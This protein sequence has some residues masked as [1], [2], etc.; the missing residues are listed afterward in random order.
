MT[1][2]DK[3]TSGRAGALVLAAALLPMFTHPAQADTTSQTPSTPTP[4]ETQIPDEWPDEPEGF[5]SVEAQDQDGTTGGHGG[6]TVTATTFEELREY[7]AVE[8]PLTI[9]IEGK[10]ESDDLGDM[11][12]VSSDTT[13]IGTG[14]DA[15]LVGGGF[16]LDEVHNVIIRNMTI[17]D[18]YVPGDWDGKDEDNDNDGIRMD[19]AHHVWVDHVAF[20]R[21]GDGMVDV[22]HGSTYVTLSWNVFA[23]HNKTL[24]IG[25]TDDV[26]THITMHHNW[27]RNTYQRNASTDNAAA[28]H[29]YNNRFERIG[30]YGMW[31]RGQTSMLLENNHFLH[32]RDPYFADEEA[33]LV[34]RG[35][36]LEDSPGLKVERGQAFDPEEHYNYRAAPADDVPDLVGDGAGPTTAIG[37]GEPSEPTEPGTTITVAL[38]GSA[39]FTSL[40]AA[41]GAIPPERQERT[42][43]TLAPGT[44]HERVNI[45]PDLPPITLQ[46][47]SEDPEDTVVSYEDSAGTTKYYLDQTHGTSGSASV[48]VLG[49][50]FR[51]E[52]ITFA[53]TFDEEEHADQEGHQA[54]A[55]RSVGDRAVLD[56]VRVLGN[57]DTLLLDTPGTDQVRRTHLT[58]CYVEGDVDFVF[59]RGTA[60]FEGCEIHSLARDGDEPGGYVSAAATDGA[61][62]YGFLFHRSRFTSEAPKGSVHLGRPWHPGGDPD[63][64]PQVLVRESHLGEH[65]ADDPWTDMSGWPWQEARFHEYDNTGPGAGNGPERPQ[66]SDEEA[67][68]HTPDAYLAGEDGWQ[69]QG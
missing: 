69:P 24:G 30:M 52:G 40:Q 56:E 9:E 2:I 50:D 57:Q 54:V 8:D 68:N 39:D 11:I 38:D 6:D 25:W 7:S 10:I 29:V 65:V 18:S 20:E 19:D 15:E 16:F 37:G 47:S 44:Y 53:N 66:M 51:A 22:R 14:D 60:V 21:L 43:I 64:S 12:E 23:D 3:A 4:Q 63:A 67:E 35:N 27:F 48:T 17:R 1:V 28:A 55:L 59:G 49:D 42:T 33:E 34:A 41:L 58:D 31:S 45:W 26:A 5:A 36:I 46:A 13:V 61:N 62:P 32:V